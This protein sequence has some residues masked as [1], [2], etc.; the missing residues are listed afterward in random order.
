MCTNFYQNR[1]R[2][3]GIIGFKKKVMEA[4]E[5]I[6]RFVMRYNRLAHRFKQHR[7]LRET[8]QRRDVTDL[9]ASSST[10]LICTF[11]LLFQTNVSI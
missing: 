7:E 10:G 3:D 5:E 4:M 9:K 2:I 8:R 11:E 6:H 1:F